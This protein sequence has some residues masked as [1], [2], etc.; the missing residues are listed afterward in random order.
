MAAQTPVSVRQE[1]HHAVPQCLLRLRDR[2]EAHHE[3]DGE[4]I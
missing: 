3:F 4:G 1:V 2:A